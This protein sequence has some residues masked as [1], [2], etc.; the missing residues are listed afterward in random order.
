[1]YHPVR[2]AVRNIYLTG[3]SMRRYTLFLPIAMI[4]RFAALSDR[5]GYKM[6]ELMRRALEEFLTR[7]DPEG[8]TKL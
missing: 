6:A 8:I 4:C 7:E 5:T 2:I 1:M 3:E